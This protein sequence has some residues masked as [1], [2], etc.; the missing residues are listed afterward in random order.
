M[1]APSDLFLIRISKAGHEV[2]DYGPYARERAM[3][4]QRGYRQHGWDAQLIPVTPKYVFTAELVC[5]SLEEALRLKALL[6]EAHPIDGAGGF[7]VHPA[8]ADA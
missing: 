1:S 2:E 5:N 3:R 7:G 6:D 8:G 4:G